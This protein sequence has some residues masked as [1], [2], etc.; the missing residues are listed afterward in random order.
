M[1]CRIFEIDRERPSSRKVGQAASLIAGGGL[2]AYPTDVNYGIGCDLRSKRAIERLVALKQRDPKKPL[3]FLCR[4]LS[5]ASRYARIDDA[6]FRLMRRLTPGP[7]TFVLV[8]SREVPKVALTRQKS[9]GIR[10]P[11]SAVV[12]AIVE[13]LGR[14]LLNTTASGVTGETLGDPREIRDLLGH[15]LDL[16]LDCGL[17]LFGTT[18]VVDLRGPVPEV[19]REG[20]GPVAEI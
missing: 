3:T 13:A 6:A 17:N 14:P 18:T 1:S 12:H 10:L 5:E 11:D 20:E 19:I 4:D 7:Y 8:A 15:G 2:V 16:V 9:V